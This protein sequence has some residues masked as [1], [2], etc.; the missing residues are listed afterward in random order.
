MGVALKTYYLEMTA[1]QDLR[2]VDLKRPEIQVI[3]AQVPCPAFNRFLYKSVGEAWSWTDKLEW[4]KEQWSDYVCRPDL[5]TW[6]AYFSG[7]PAGYFE[8][9]KHCESVEIAYFGL[10]PQFIG[11]GIGG[12]LLTCAVEQAWAMEVQR[13]W[14]HTCTLDHPS[15]LSN[16]QARG[17]RVF[18]REQP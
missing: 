8:L 2:P 4:S 15:A 12:H 18:K 10:F 5:Q 3:Q 14:V 11:Q 6:V 13:I 16:Y 9:E 7:T 17:F 1:P